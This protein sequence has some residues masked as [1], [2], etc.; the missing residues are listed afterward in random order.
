M[1]RSGSQYT[2]DSAKRSVILVSMDGF[3][4][5]CGILERILKALISNT[6]IRAKFTSQLAPRAC[7][8]GVEQSTNQLLIVFSVN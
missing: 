4:N 2:N 7:F 3:S 8:D 1:K 6:R 5:K